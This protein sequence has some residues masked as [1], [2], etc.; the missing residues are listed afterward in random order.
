MV[1]LHKHNAETYRKTELW[2]QKFQIFSR[3]FQGYGRVPKRKEM[4]EDANKCPTKKVNYLMNKLKNL[5][6]L[7]FRLSL[8]EKV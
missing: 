2:E 7:V 4:Y 5:M 1:K 3:F 6:K 8:T